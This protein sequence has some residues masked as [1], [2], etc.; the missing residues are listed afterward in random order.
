MDEHTFTHS[1]LYVPE[2]PISL[3]ERDTFI[4]WELLIHLMGGK[5]EIG[6][7]LDKGRRM[8]MLMTEDRAP[9]AKQADLS[10]RYAVLSAAPLH[11]AHCSLLE[12]RCWVQPFCT[13][14]AKLRSLHSPFAQATLVLRARC[15]ASA[16]ATLGANQQLKC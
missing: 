14:P 4:N 1:F 13:W 16:R 15:K 6:V 3:L 8:R 11:L 5:L 10:R 2:C 12:L 9:Q 7:P